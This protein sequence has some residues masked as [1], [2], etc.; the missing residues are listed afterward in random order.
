MH[1]RNQPTN[2]RSTRPQQITK[3]KEKYCLDKETALTYTEEQ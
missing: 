1:K 2:V 3:I